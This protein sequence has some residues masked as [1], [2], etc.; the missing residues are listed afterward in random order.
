MSAAA[1]IP[2]SDLARF[3]LSS[4]AVRQLDAGLD[5]VDLFRQGH[6]D[7]AYAC[8]RRENPLPEM[9]SHIRPDPAAPR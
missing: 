6:L 5:W 9:T 2:E 8:L 1:P 4:D 3:G 7:E